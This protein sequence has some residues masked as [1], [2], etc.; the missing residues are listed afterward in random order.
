ML[1][2]ARKEDKYSCLANTHIFEPIAFE[3]LGPWT[4]L[5]A[6]ICAIWVVEPQSGQMKYVKPV[7]FFNVFRSIFNVLIVL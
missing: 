3:T 1:A 2:A 5:L 6:L 4:Q 7:S